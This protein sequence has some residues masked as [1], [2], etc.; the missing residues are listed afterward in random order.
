MSMQLWVH[1]YIELPQISF[2]YYCGKEGE[3][4]VKI[5]HEL[6]LMSIAIYLLFLGQGAEL[7]DTSSRTSLKGEA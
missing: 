6:D 4:E 5:T 1:R 3:K 2:S 7:L